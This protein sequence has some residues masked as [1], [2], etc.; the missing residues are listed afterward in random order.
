MRFAAENYT[1]ACAYII[2][3]TFAINELD[4]CM[5]SGGSIVSN[6]GNIQFVCSADNPCLYIVLWPF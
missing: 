6:A 4:T 2:H 3:K 1:N 5:L